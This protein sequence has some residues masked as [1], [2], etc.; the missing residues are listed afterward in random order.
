MANTD[1][2]FPDGQSFETVFRQFYP[3]LRGYA[4]KLLSDEALADEAVQEV[5]MKIWQ[6]K[7]ELNIQ[8][9]V[10]SYLFRA[11]HNHCLNMIKSQKIKE[12]HHQH[13]AD[14][15]PQADLTDSM[16]TMEAKER[17]YGAIA[18]LPDQCARIFRMSRFE[19]LKY[20]E[21]AQKLSISPKTVE[22]QMGK[23]LKRLREDLK[24]F[25]VLLIFFLFQ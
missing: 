20:K 11:V 16:E 7:A 25:L 12:G 19:G 9:S 17:I 8:T 14:I 24:D 10:K 1:Y 2:I 21:I 18:R 4:L 23:A 22:V 5:F 13:I 15:T 6:K 3:G